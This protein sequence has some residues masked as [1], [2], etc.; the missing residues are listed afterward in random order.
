MIASARRAL[1]AV[2]GFQGCADVPEVRAVGSQPGGVLR[3]DGT[4]EVLCN[5]CMSPQRRHEHAAR[6]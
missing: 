1:A 4:D 2:P 6:K 3:P 5:D